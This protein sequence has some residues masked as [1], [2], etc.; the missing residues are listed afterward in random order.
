MR[1]CHKT[2]S[3]INIFIQW[4]K[5]SCEAGQAQKNSGQVSFGA[6]SCRSVN[7]S[8]C[9]NDENPDEVVRG[10]T[11]WLPCFEA[12][13]VYLTITDSVDKNESYDATVPATAIGTYRCPLPTPSPSYRW[14]NG[15]AH[16]YQATSNPTHSLP[17]PFALFLIVLDSTSILT[18]S[19][20]FIKS[21]RR[22]WNEL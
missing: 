8:H 7:L 11:A 6:H 22:L 20:V 13:C 4:R 19:R 10:R 3:Q 21:V 14:K 16:T 15:F 1:D 17:S 18:A 2:T 5:T 9:D 12:S